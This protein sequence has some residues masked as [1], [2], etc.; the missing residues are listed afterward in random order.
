MTF[1]PLLQVIDITTED[2]GTIRIH[3]AYIRSLLPLMLEVQYY[4]GVEA[5]LDEV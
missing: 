4:E 3:N 2:Y 5:R 1:P